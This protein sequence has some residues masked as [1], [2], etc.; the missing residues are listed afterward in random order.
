M[1]NQFYS[2]LLKL[3]TQLFPDRMR[4]MGILTKSSF[5]TLGLYLGLVGNVFSSNIQKNVPNYGRSLLHTHACFC[6]RL[7]QWLQYGLIFLAFVKCFIEE[8]LIIFGSISRFGSMCTMMLI[9]WTQ[10][11]MLVAKYQ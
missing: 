9:T 8:S 4:I 11:S 10:P 3:I 5:P 2:K 7:H 1:K 6:S